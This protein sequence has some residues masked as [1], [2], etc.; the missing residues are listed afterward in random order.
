MGAGDGGRGSE[1]WQAR[2]GD[3]VV[4]GVRMRCPWLL[5]FGTMTLATCGPI[6]GEPTNEQLQ[7]KLKM[8]R[9]LLDELR[10]M[11]AEDTARHGL[12]SIGSSAHHDAACR[13]RRRGGDC[14]GVER[15]KEYASR[16]EPAGIEWIQQ[17]ETQGVYFQVYRRPPTWG[18]S[19]THRS[20][21]LVFA[22][23]S[24][25]VID[26]HDDLEYRVN[27]G[28]GWYAYLILDD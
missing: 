27:L 12:R 22:P 10:G 13:G 23:G 24:P 28:D 16:L 1:D 14:L 20:R 5:L 11:F 8:N 15:W 25:Q 3:R 26:N 19:G 7:L 6:I 18:W 9:Q 4:S 21:G 2:A 17:H